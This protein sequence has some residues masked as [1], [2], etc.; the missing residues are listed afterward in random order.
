MTIKQINNRIPVKLRNNSFFAIFFVLVYCLAMFV[1]KPFFN[2]LLENA[3]QCKNEKQGKHIFLV[4]MDILLTFTKQNILPY[5]YRIYAFGNKSNKERREYIS[6]TD[7]LAFFKRREINLLPDDK[8]KRFLMFKDL[9]HRQILYFSF[10][11]ACQ[12]EEMDRFKNFKI[13]NKEAI[14]KPIRGSKGLGVQKI[15]LT[16][17]ESLCE[18]KKYIGRECVLEQ[19]IVQSSEIGKFHPES[20]NTI[21]FVSAINQEGKYTHLFSMLRTG[22]G[23]SVVDNVGSGGIIALIDENGKIVSDGMRG[24]EYF[25]THPDTNIKF[26]GF[27]I[28]YYDE[29]CELVKEAHK[30][31]PGQRLLGWD[32]ALSTKGWDLVEVNPAPSFRSYQ[33]LTGKGIIP[34]HKDVGLYY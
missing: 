6:V 22:C 18:L 10:K 28:P 25:I 7:S 5:E 21:R 11:S 30:K 24:G 34:I 1:D 31:M 16:M 26:K 8:Y 27:T 4:F 17:I 13:H 20:V 15:D 2:V 32:F 14:I 12:K 29:L 33:V 23:G 9:F 3:K 19:I